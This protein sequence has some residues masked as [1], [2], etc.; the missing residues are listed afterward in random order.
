MTLKM[1]RIFLSR[2]LSRELTA[3]STRVTFLKTFKEMVK[4]GNLPLT[5]TN[6]TIIGY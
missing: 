3:K 1:H 6:T 5:D 4:I 2:L